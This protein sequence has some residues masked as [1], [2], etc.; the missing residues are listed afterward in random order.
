MGLITTVEGPPESILG[1]KK[2]ERFSEYGTLLRITSE[3]SGYIYSFI[4]LSLMQYM[5]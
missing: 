1:I 3:E 4:L 5:S 2:V